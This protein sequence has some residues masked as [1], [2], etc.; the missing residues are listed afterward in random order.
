ML[1]ADPD[2]Q[3]RMVV[4]ALKSE[5]GTVKSEQTAWM[6]LPRGVAGTEVYLSRPRDRATAWNVL[7]VG[8]HG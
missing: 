3:M 5:N 2:G 7:V 8:V 4:A 6:A 1:R